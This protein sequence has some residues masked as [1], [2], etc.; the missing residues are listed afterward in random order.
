MRL[1]LQWFRYGP[2]KCEFV[3]ECIC[4]CRKS[5]ANHWI[6][7]DSMLSF[8]TLRSITT[9]SFAF[10]AAAATAAAETVDVLSAQREYKHFQ[11]SS[12]IYPLMVWVTSAGCKKRGWK[13]V[14]RVKLDKMADSITTEGLEFPYTLLIQHFIFSAFFYIANIFALIFIFH[15]TK[16]KSTWKKMKKI[17]T[18]IASLSNHKKMLLHASEKK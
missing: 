13:T 11:S 3:Y 10:T 15:W 4:V 8:Y 5:I 12:F 9:I 18:K 16:K 6:S 17:K 2:I 7:I 1:S 14:N